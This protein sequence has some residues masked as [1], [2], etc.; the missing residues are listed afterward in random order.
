MQHRTL[1][2]LKQIANID[3]AQPHSQPRQK[4]MAQRDRLERW[5]HLLR[6]YPNRSLNSLPGTEYQPADRRDA[7]RRLGSPISVAFSDPVL[8]AAGL[9]D[10]TYGEAKRFFGLSDSQLHNIVCF[11]RS[12]DHISAASAA[13]GVRAAIVTSMPPSLVDRIVRYFMR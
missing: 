2:Q 13:Y 11:C 5:A 9:R 3:I 1:D 6:Q 12:G 10:D 7:M 8:R 4:S